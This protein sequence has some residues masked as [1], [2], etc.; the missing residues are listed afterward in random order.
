MRTN[1]LLI[2]IALVLVFLVAINYFLILPFL[3]D[4]LLTNSGFTSWLSTG[5]DGKKNLVAEPRY[6]VNDE[7]VSFLRAKYVRESDGMEN[8]CPYYLHVFSHT[9]VGLPLVVL[10]NANDKSITR[11]AYLEKSVDD[12][13]YRHYTRICD[14]CFSDLSKWRSYF[15]PVVN[16]AS[17]S[18]VRTN[19]ANGANVLVVRKFRVNSL[20]RRYAY[21]VTFERDDKTTERIIVITFTD[22]VRSKSWR[23]VL[24]GGVTWSKLYEYYP[25]LSES[26]ENDA[27]VTLSRCLPIEILERNDGSQDVSTFMSDTN[28]SDLSLTRFDTTI[29]NGSAVQ[30][31]CWSEEFK[32]SVVKRAP[33]ELDSFYYYYMRGLQ[34]PSSAEKTDENIRE[35]LRTLYFDCVY[36][37]DRASQK[38]SR[39]DSLASNIFSNVAI[40]TDHILYSVVPILRSC[41]VDPSLDRRVYDDRL[42]QC[43][44]EK[45]R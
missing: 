24:K 31:P 4:N 2:E 20:R 21:R 15:K 36:D 37:R 18:V 27:F 14:T 38:A 11:Y 28:S 3:H 30:N 10:I 33:V 35:V 5:D 45:K 12:S 44:R 8:A 6:E 40:D 25:H 19:F 23:F 32:R 34:L 26:E 41:N 22:R 13:K 42:Q 17:S 29:K 43:V 9:N 16:A 7:L 39:D 1:N